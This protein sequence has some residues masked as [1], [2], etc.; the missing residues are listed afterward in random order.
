M[1]NWFSAKSSQELGNQLAVLLM[2]LMPN[3]VQL[4]ESK[5]VSKANFAKE[6]MLKLVKAFKQS[7]KLNFYK[8]S[9]LVNTFNWKLKDAGFDKV[10]AAEFASWLVFNLSGK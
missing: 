2:E 7:E 4:N 10:L 3:N 9:K 6:K 1:L 8:I 5:R